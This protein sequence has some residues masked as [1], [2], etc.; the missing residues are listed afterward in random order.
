MSTP[1]RTP[2]HGFT[3]YNRHGD[4]L[5]VDANQHRAYIEDMERH[6]PTQGETQMT[7]SANVNVNA[8]RT[9]HDLVGSNEV[10]FGTFDA[11]GREYGHSFKVHCISYKV[12]SDSDTSVPC[13]WIGTKFHVAPQSNRNGVRFGATA[14]SSRANFDT[15]AEALAYGDA[16]IA[17]ARKARA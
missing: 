4:D 8:R 7:K 1:R 2:L 12:E 15:L 9:G 11:K 10:A 5:A 17:K 6:T 3:R 14:V 13:N 16:A